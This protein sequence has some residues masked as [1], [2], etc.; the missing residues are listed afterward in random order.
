MRP[1]DEAKIGAAFVETAL[2]RNELEQ[3]AM[4]L[5][6]LQ[7]ALAR[8]NDRLSERVA[9]PKK[10]PDG[11]AGQLLAAD[12]EGRTR[13]TDPVTV[14]DGMVGQVVERW[15]RAHPEATT[16]VA[17]RAITRAKLSDDIANALDFGRGMPEQAMAMFGQVQAEVQ[18]GTDIRRY[19]RVTG[20]YREKLIRYAEQFDGGDGFG[21]IYFTDPH[22]I[23]NTFGESEITMLTFLQEMKAL[24]EN[25]PA[26]FVLCG[27]DILNHEQNVAQ[28]R[29]HAAGALKLLKGW[30]SE[31]TYVVPGNHDLGYLP[32]GHSIITPERL[33]ALWHGR[34]VGYDV[35]R[36]FH[37][38][39]YLF[40]SGNCV[41][42]MNDYRWSQVHWFGQ[43]LQANM[44]PH[45]FGVIHI[46]HYQL[47]G[48]HEDQEIP[49]ELTIRLCAVADAFNRRT[50]IAL[51]GVSYDFTQAHGTFHFMLSGH[52]H[53]DLCLECC[54]IPVIC[55]DASFLNRRCVDLCYADFERHC[56]R[57][58]RVGQGE[59][60]NLPIIP[61]GGYTVQG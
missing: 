7:T 56:L 36:D 43:R 18:A 42:A 24:Y 29:M 26:R 38:D 53:M 3:Q 9:K 46:P 6:R 51:N 27:G 52:M 25:T 13:W 14:S 40:D 58:I 59:S 28:A 50:C 37:T 45:L 2:I 61:G 44:Q 30:I 5:G 8:L 15:L 23:G 35:I 16:T 54:H 60:R 1:E 39:C 31:H 34:P 17:D 19:L 47:G 10:R 12:G 41:A 22:L 32:D 57:M 20:L 48:E 55:T 21:F 33:A 11:S 4:E 49:F